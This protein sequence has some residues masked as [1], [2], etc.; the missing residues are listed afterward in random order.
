MIIGAVSENK[1]SEKRISITP[2]IA[3]KYLDNGFNVIIENDLASHLG[4]SDEDFKK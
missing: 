2:E 1:N 3:K 4:I